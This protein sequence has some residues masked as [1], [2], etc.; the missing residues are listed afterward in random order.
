MEKVLLD[1]SLGKGF[2]IRDAV[3][4]GQP[5]VTEWAAEPGT[6][7]IGE[8]NTYPPFFYRSLRF[9]DNPYHVFTSPAGRFRIFADR[10]EKAVLDPE[11]EEIL[12]LR[13]ESYIAERE[14]LEDMIIPAFAGPLLD[15]SL[16]QRLGKPWMRNELMGHPLHA[17]EHLR[18]AEELRD[19]GYAALAINEYIAALMLDR[20][21]SEAFYQLAETFA[22]IDRDGA[23]KHYETFLKRFGARAE[24]A[25]QAEKA[26]RFLGLP[27]K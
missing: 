13:Y 14:S 25:G 8:V 21:F 22:T 19:R 27:P 7:S 3:R 12:R 2:T 20:N 9:D 18:L 17:V 1:L 16:A 15:R 24:C 11:Q 10:N 6:V 4:T 5:V 26:R 23:R